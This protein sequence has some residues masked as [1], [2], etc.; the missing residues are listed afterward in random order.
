M[1]T[2]YPDGV[3]LSRVKQ[4]QTKNSFFTTT[5]VLQSAFIRSCSLGCRGVWW[6]LAGLSPGVA[7][8]LLLLFVAFAVRLGS[9]WENQVNGG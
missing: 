2:R 7:E 9:H 5:A 8:M 3:Y 1:Y 6:C 4:K